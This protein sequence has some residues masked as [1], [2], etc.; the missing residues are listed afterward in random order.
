MQDVTTSVLDDD[1]V[2]Q[3]QNAA[4]RGPCVVQYRLPG[5]T[6]YWAHP[7]PGFAATQRRWI[8]LAIVAEVGFRKITHAGGHHVPIGRKPTDGP[9]WLK[10]S[11]TASIL[12]PRLDRFKVSSA[13]DTTDHRPPRAIEPLQLHL[14][15][16]RVVVRRGIQSDARQQHWNRNILQV[17]RLLQHVSPESGCRR[18]VSARPRPWRRCNSRIPLVCRSDPGPVRRF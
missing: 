1:R 8:C 11:G 12:Q 4:P 18:T 13:D 16:R 9:P 15:D 3:R 10:S 14:L 2:Q 7:C 6:R 17:G 5:G